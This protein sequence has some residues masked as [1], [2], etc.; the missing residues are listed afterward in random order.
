TQVMGYIQDATQVI[1][2][3]R[4]TV[5]AWT[6]GGSQQVQEIRA[7]LQ[8]VEEALLRKGRAA[9]EHRTALSSPEAIRAAFPD[10]LR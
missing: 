5:D 6:Q 9:R 1:A 7:Q 3:I 10:F 4:T 2:L 8:V